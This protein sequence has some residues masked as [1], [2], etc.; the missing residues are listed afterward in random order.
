METANTKLINTYGE[1]HLSQHLRVDELR[2]EMIR[3]DQVSILKQRF[4]D[5]LIT[6]DD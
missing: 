6:Q 2:T 3:F 5:E 1:T 4:L